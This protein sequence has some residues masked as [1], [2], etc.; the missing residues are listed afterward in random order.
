MLYVMAYYGRWLLDVTGADTKQIVP[1][2]LLPGI[3]IGVSD[4]FGR[5]GGG[6]PESRWKNAAGAVLWAVSFSVVAGWLTP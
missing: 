6:W 3:V 5:T 2:M 1:L 4:C